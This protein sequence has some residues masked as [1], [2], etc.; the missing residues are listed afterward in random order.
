[1]EGLARMGVDLGHDLQL[2]PRRRLHARH[3]GARQHMKAARR[4][5]RLGREDRD[6]KGDGTFGPTEQIGD[7]SC[8]CC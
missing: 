2:K 4:R 6:S 3:H 5:P 1:M 8:R 7:P